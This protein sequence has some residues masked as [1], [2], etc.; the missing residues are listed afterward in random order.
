MEGL[1]FRNNYIQ[2]QPENIHKRLESSENFTAL[3]T[4]K[5]K[6]DTV[7]FAS[8]TAEDAKDNF[9]T[10]TMK[11]LGISNPKRFFISLGLTLATVVGLAILGNKSSNKMAE[12]GQKVDDFLLNNKLYSSVANFL[13]KGK[14]SVVKF[15]R[16]SQTIDDVFTTMNDPIR[17]ARVECDMTRGYGQ[18]FSSIFDLTPVSILKTS[19][20]H[21][22]NE[23]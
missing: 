11:G 3:D 12:L 5:L 15:L 19:F 4:D 2:N 21:S 6:Q 14:D 20:Q 16:K 10:R 7:E 1:T 23:T 17:K 8:K 9:F 22:S 18:G 13:K